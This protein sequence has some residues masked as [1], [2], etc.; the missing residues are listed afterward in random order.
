MSSDAL[1]NKIFKDTY[2]SVSVDRNRA[3]SRVHRAVLDSRKISMERNFKR[4]L[5]NPRKRKVISMKEDTKNRDETLTR[6][7]EKRS[8]DDC[9]FF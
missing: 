2:V 3:S 8:T 4:S 1:A 6:E 9:R 7:R 5:R